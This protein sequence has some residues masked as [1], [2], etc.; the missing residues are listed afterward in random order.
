MNQ[1]INDSYRPIVFRYGLIG[2]LGLIAIPLIFELAGLT[3]PATGEGNNMVLGLS[4]LIMVGAMFLAIRQ[5][6]EDDLQGRITFGRALSVAFYTALVMCLIGAVYFFIY[7]SFINPEL[8]DIIKANAEAQFEQRGMSDEEIKQ[9][10]SMMEMWVNP[11]VMTITSFVTNV[12]LS[13]IAALIL[14]AVLQN[15][16]K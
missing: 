3:D 11:T 6:K 16:K 15:D 9:G 14:A 7:V 2:G 10:L 1:P 4:L 8:L 13:G 12:I 5:H